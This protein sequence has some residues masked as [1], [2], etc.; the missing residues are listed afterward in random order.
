MKLIKVV[1]ILLIT[2]IMLIN[3]GESDS[4]DNSKI[5]KEN[6]IEVSKCMDNCVDENDVYIDGCDDE[7]LKKLNAK[8][9]KVLNDY[10]QC[11]K[12]AGCDDITDE[13][14]MDTCFEENCSTEGELW[15]QCYTI[16]T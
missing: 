16:G 8:N 5:D 12:D 7:C 2:I 11:I 15:S 3:C 6:C 13:D 1:P 4:T 10:K 14:E 9:E